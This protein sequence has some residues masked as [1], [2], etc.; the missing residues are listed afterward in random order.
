M[1]N[2]SKKK[3][4]KL[5]LILLPFEIGKRLPINL[6]AMVDYLLGGSDKMVRDK[7]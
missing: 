6:T 3:V 4:Q 1:Y 2:K 7:N 5:F